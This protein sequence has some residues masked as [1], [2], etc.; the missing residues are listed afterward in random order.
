MANYI[1]N[2]D[3]TILRLNN[4]GMDVLYQNLLDTVKQL[5]LDKNKHLMDFVSHLDQNTYGSG[6]IYID[7]KD[8]FGQNHLPKDLL[9][10]IVK[11]AIIRIKE[12][13]KWDQALIEPLEK[14]ENSLV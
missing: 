13:G 1:L 4:W 8:Y 5:S 9:H 6:A 10:K 7:I 2:N 11:N 3:I 14:F 12:T